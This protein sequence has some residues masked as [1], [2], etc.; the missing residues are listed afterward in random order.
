MAKTKR[1]AKTFGE[2]VQIF[3]SV[4]AISL[5]LYRESSWNLST[6]RRESPN[7]LGRKEDALESAWS[8]FSYDELMEYISEKTVGTGT[9]RRL[10]R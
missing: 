2:N 10:R 5:V 6:L 9:T 1:S 3:N 8:E 4:E 7:D